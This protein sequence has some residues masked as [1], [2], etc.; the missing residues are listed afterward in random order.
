[1][2]LGLF[3]Y[4]TIFYIVISYKESIGTPIHVLRRLQ[5][6]LVSCPSQLYR[7]LTY[8]HHNTFCH[9]SRIKKE[10]VSTNFYDSIN[11]K[12]ETLFQ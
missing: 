4:N 3:P 10:L 1:M 8:I 11:L 2:T 6:F 7:F 12:Y 5:Y 9:G